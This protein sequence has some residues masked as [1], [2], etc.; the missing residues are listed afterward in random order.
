MPPPEFLKKLRENIS[1]N[2]NFMRRSQ[3]SARKF[4]EGR[5]SRGFGNVSIIWTIDEN[6]KLKP[7][8]VITGL[9]DNSY[10]EIVRVLR[11]ELKEGQE[12]VVGMEGYSSSR[13]SPSPIRGFMMIRR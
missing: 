12:I 5:K 11:G 9:T 6:K 4:S 13:R 10:T 8:P 2:Q 3:G 1:K 7:I